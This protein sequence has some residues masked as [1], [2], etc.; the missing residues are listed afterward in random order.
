M[1]SSPI[2]VQFDENLPYHIMGC[3]PDIIAGILTYW[4]YWLL[5]SLLVRYSRTP[6][7]SRIVSLTSIRTTGSKWKSLAAWYSD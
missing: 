5:F 6:H 4:V 3:E 1:A 2:T 7:S